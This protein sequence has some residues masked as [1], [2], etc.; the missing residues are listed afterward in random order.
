MVNG[1]V[2]FIGGWTISRSTLG[3]KKNALPVLRRL[4]SLSQ[5]ASDLRY[6]SRADRVV[7]QRESHLVMAILMRR[8]PSVAVCGVIMSPD[9]CEKQVV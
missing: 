9:D 3:A 4:M 6:S 7:S 8:P 1:N 2:L 5:T